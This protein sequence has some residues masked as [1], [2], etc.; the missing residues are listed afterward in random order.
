MGKTEE[1]Q[2][3][4]K[5]VAFIAKVLDMENE[6]A[7]VLNR[8][9]SD[10]PLNEIPAFFKYR[11]GFH[12]EHSSKEMVTLKAYR[13][14]TRKKTV[15]KI[16]KGEFVFTDFDDMVEWIQTYF[17][18]EDLTKGAHGFKSNVILRV[19]NTKRL[20]DTS[21]LSEQGFPTILD[22]EKEVKVYE[23]LFLNQKKIGYAPL[24]SGE[25]KKELEALLEKKLKEESGLPIKATEES[26]MG[27][28]SKEEYEPDFHKKEVLPPLD[29]SAI[30][31]ILKG[32]D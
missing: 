13:S 5:R 9:I 21:D 25:R 23:W 1:E 4:E 29:I 31:G 27:T 16:Q 28:T 8:F 26:T 10:I 18:G 6:R 22:A 12:E 2:V 3:T 20:L 17:M 30:E 19:S 7:F 14:Y 32:S 24:L 15:S 11:I